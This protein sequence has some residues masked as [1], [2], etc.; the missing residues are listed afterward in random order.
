[1]EVVFFIFLVLIIILALLF[2]LPVRLSM[3]VAGD[4]F[5]GFRLDGR[6]H[7]FNGLIG[8]G[9]ETDGS[10]VVGRLFFLFRRVVE[11]DLSGII[12]YFRKKAAG[13]AVAKEEKKKPAPKKTTGERLQSFRGN[14]GKGKGILRDL[15][16]VFRLDRLRTHVTLGLLRPE[17]TGVMTGIIFA[18]NGII[19][20]RYEIVPRW[21]F[22][23][24]ALSGDLLVR[25]T[26]VNY[27]LWMKLFII[28]PKVL[29]R[30][31]AT[32]FLRQVKQRYA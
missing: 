14:L 28:L 1:M 5:N 13:R 19:P 11:F 18:L 3:F 8:G 6:L 2:L 17:I 12:A 16:G 9:V 25:I 29:D 21:D 31:S 10:R 20:D 32:R 15:K 4:M 26:V 7:V 22:T 23:A 30:G 24:N 27:I